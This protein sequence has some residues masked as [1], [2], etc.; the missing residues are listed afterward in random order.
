MT[1]PNRMIR[2]HVT[3]LGEN[4]HYY[5]KKMRPSGET[6]RRVEELEARL[7]ATDARLAELEARMT[8]HADEWGMHR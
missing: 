4:R 2:L 1:D 5:A 3:N 7:R 6:H 8:A